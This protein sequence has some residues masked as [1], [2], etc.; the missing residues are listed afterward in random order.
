M[1]EVDERRLLDAVGAVPEID[2]VQVLLQDPLLRPRL[3][4]LELPGERGLAHLA[5][6]RLL[7]AVER[8]LH[9]L[10]RDRRAALD[11]LL[12][13]DVRDE[14][15]ADAAQVDPVV[16]PEPPVLDRD[17]RVAHRVG[18]LVVL[19]QRA[20]LGAAEDREDP[21]AARVVDVA[22]DL[23]VELALRVEL[24]GLD[25]SRDS[26]DQPEAERHRPEEA[27]DGEEREEAKPADPATPTRR[28]LLERPQG[29]DCSLSRSS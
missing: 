20:C 27:Q 17:D 1:P 12:L 9:E 29:A 3:R 25:F 26:T 16:L 18:D 2:R 13:A 14:G 4:T 28:S 11:D 21:L 10:L 6:D 8:V 7:V 23:L 22:V 24:A 15:A 19:D 5:G